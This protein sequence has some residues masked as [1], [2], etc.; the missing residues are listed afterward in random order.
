MF[1]DAK[2]K[3]AEVLVSLIRTITTEDM[4]GSV[5][6]SKRDCII[7]KNKTAEIP[8]TANLSLNEKQTPV[9]FEPHVNPDVPDGL[10]VTEAVLNLKGGPCQLF[11]LQ[12]VNSTDRDILLPGRTQLG[13]MQL[14]CSITPVDVKIRD[15]DS[16]ESDVVDKPA[17]TK[18]VTPNKVSPETTVSGQD[19]AVIEQ[20]DLSDL[21]PDQA[22]VAKKILTEEVDSFSCNDQDVGCAPGLELDIKLTDDKP[23][24][25]NYASIPRGSQRLYPGL[26]KS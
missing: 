16:L 11:N 9:I 14:V 2:P 13:S 20:I 25:K 4:L 22:A 12:I 1:D 17:E 24:H 26:I 10:S 5:K 19:Q 3:N 23:V 8:C 6:T 7:P 21:T 15:T 18:N